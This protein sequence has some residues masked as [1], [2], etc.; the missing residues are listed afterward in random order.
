MQSDKHAKH[1]SATKKKNHIN[2]GVCVCVN[3]R[4]CTQSDETTRFYTKSGVKRVTLCV[5]TGRLRLKVVCYSSKATSTTCKHNQ[6][7][8]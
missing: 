4:Q 5:F 2:Q 3:D 7:L 1:I 8:L 6:R